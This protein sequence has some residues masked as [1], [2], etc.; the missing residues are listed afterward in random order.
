M[1]N[2]KDLTR[3]AAFTDQMRVPVWDQSA[4]QPRAV[5]GAQLL[6]AANANAIAVAASVTNRFYPGSYPSDPAT[7]PDGSAIQQGDIY[8]NSSVNAHKAFS[9]A[10]WI[11]FDINAVALAASGGSAL[12]GFQQSGTGA[13][14][15]LAQDKMRDVIDLRDFMTG[16]EQADVLNAF[17]S[18]DLTSKLAAAQTQ[19]ETFG[20]ANS[21]FP[22]IRLPSGNVGLAGFVWTKNVSIEGQE[23]GNTRLVYVGADNTAGTYLV[24]IAA[25]SG[26]VPY[27]GFYNL[28][29]IGCDPT[30]STS[31]PACEN[32]ILNLGVNL[33]WGF[34]LQNV[35]FQNFFGDAAQL[36]GT[37]SVFV[38]LFLNRIRWDGVGGFGIFLGSNNL[39]SGSPF[40]LDQ[41]TMDNNI[42]GNFATKM[43]GQGRYDGSRWGKGL[44]R[45]E[46]GQN[47]GAEISNARIELNKKLVAHNGGFALIYSNQ[48]IASVRC[49]VTAKNLHGTSRSD[50]PVSILRDVTGRTDFSFQ[51]IGIS[52][53][54][55]LLADDTKP[56]RDI[57][58]NQV[59]PGFVGSQTT[60]QLGTNI[61]GHALEF[62]PNAPEQVSGNFG[63]Y[64]FGDVVFNTTLG[65]G[66]PALWQMKSPTTGFAVGAANNITTTAVV[67]SGSATVTVGSTT[68]ANLAIGL[69]ITLVGAGPAA[70]DLPTRVTA[71]DETTTSITVADVPS[72]SVNPATIKFAA[73]QFA[74]VLYVPGLSAD[75]GNTSVTVTLGV[76]EPTQYFNTAL[77]ANKTVTLA[78]S[79]AN[80]GTVAQA[81]GGKF[82]IVRTAASTGAFTLDIAHNAGTKSLATGQWA[83]FEFNGTVWILTAAGSL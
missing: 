53:F 35:H 74:P 25:G 69:N 44:I 66:R 3:A 56:E 83:D 47:I 80:L 37:N 40:V 24:G 78:T 67:T 9:G 29:F 68:L 54:A 38:N 11:A 19:A 39:N 61:Y 18:V 6:A 79:A 8:F 10:L 13:V 75:K 22:R 5:T 14:P 36:R 50:Q 16:A 33:D 28:D 63:S 49:F 77:T 59:G 21:R 4:E 23:V 1:A 46:D 55:R 45:I 48:T 17:P 51:Q 81:N 58:H 72:T 34:K 26:A 52:S 15:R 7:R 27:A 57:Y 42:T 41:F 43:T 76:N 12:V 73:C 60:Q 82:R 20:A 71:V 65:V 70:A 31:N 64:K 32:G 62:R 2:I 30:T